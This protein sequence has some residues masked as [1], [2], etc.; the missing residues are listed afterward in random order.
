[1]NPARIAYLDCFG[2]ISGDMLLGAL[3]GA[4]AP[5]AAVEKAVRGLGLRGVRLCVRTVD[6]AGFAATKFD[7]FVKTAHGVVEG[8]HHHAAPV[9]QGHAPAQGHGHDHG[10]G[11]GHPHIPAR[12]ILARI[13]AAKLSERVKTSSLAVFERLARAEAKAHG[14]TVASVR[15]H[16]VGAVDSIVDVVGAAA[17]LEAL[18]IEA[19]YVSSLP[20]SRGHIHGAHGTIPV[21]GPAALE[22]MR[23]MSVAP[24]DVEGEMV[25]PTGAAI[26]RE[27]AR[28]AGTCPA[29]RI[30]AV[31]IGAGGRDIPGRPNILRVL[32]GVST[33]A[34][35]A[36]AVWVVE[37]NLDNLTGEVVGHVLEEL[38]R[39]GA[40]DAWTAPIQMKKSRPGVVV[41]AICPPAA[42]AAVEGVL[43]RETPTFGVRRHRAERTMLGRRHVT[44]RTPYGPV[45]VKVGTRCGA[46]VTASPEYEDCRAA[47]ARR[48]APLRDV[49]RA[50]LEAFRAP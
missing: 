3:V 45:R 5:L 25:T 13:R 6:R 18:G 28:S 48:G 7:V 9:A 15:F 38:F 34:E 44:V 33:P 2:G 8:G 49:I 41:S 46:V 50:A 39:A 10:H 47:A 30:E 36:D 11:H 37:T 23:G 26:V 17:A 14:K 1:M 24:A 29:M 43:F 40:V 42:L 16:E 21:P 35:E 27:M 32:V 31:G 22:L 19:V 20:M 12:E 4:G